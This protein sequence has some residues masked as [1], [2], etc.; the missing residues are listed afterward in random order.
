MLTEIIERTVHDARTPIIPAVGSW[1]Q[2]KS[3]R[4][5]V[6][7]N[8][9]NIVIASRDPSFAKIFID[10]DSY[11]I[12]D[13][14]G[15]VLAARVLRMAPI[16]RQSGVDVM[17]SILESLNGKQKV[18]LVG[19]SP[20]SAQRV[21]EYSHV[22]YGDTLAF[23]VL[24]DVDKNDPQLIERVVLEK[25]DVLFVAFGSPFQEKWIDTHRDALSG[26]VCMGVGGAFDF[27]AGKVP[28]APVWMQRIGCEWLFRLACEPWRI[29]RQTRLIVFVILLFMSRWH[30]QKSS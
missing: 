22:K 9:E 14:V 5:I 10:R 27:I 1:I 26:V 6:S 21:A 7:V 15:T 11:C 3:F 13:G 20:G 4:H 19:G 30:S 23:G 24:G 18:V 28:R 2:A 29:V 8:P 16:V 25:P 17:T 12:A